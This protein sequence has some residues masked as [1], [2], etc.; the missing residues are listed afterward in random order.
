M[1]IKLANLN[2]RSLRDRRKVAHM[3][4]DLL[5]FG[6]DLAA[7]QWTHFVCDVDASVL[8]NDFVVYSVYWDRQ[9]RGVYLLLKRSLD[10]RVGRLVVADIAV[11]NGSFRVVAVL[12]T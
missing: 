10:A 12:C 8:P 3:L 7:I 4:R 11:N 1:S 6:V 2:V 5:S 9:S